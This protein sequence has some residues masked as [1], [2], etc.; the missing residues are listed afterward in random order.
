MKFTQ[1]LEITDASGAGTGRWRAVEF[2]DEYEGADPLCDCGG[3]SH[4]DPANA[5]HGSALAALM[6]SAAQAKIRARQGLAE[7]VD[8]S[9]TVPCDVCE[10]RRTVRTISTVSYPD[11]THTE[12]PTRSPCPRCRGE[13]TRPAV[14]DPMA[15]AHV[16]VTLPIVGGS[17]RLRSASGGLEALWVH[18]CDEKDQRIALD[19]AT[20]CWLPAAVRITPTQARD[21]AALLTRYADTH[22]ETEE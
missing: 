21:L 9:A 7:P 20:G 18:I 17:I 2:S 13:G 5:G 19:R 11:D 6:C 14:R 10:G 3:R 15:A 1:A 12:T 8:A 22:R 4:A 16:D